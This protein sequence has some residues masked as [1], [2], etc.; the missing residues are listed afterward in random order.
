GDQVIVSATVSP[1]F[2]E[3]GKVTHYVG[4]LFDVTKAKKAEKQL[5]L[6]ATVFDSATEAV[7]VSDANNQILT[8]NR[9]FSV[10]TGY[11]YD[12][13]VGKNPKILSSGR[14]DGDYYLGMYK[15]LEEAGSWEGE[16]WNRR[17]NGS[18]YPEWLTIT[19]L[20]D[21]RGVHEGYVAI[22]SDITK[23]KEDELR[24]IHQANY[25]SLTGLA[26]RNLFS[27]RYTRAIERAERE[28]S[29]LALLFIDLDR[30]KY[31]N[32]TLGHAIG[33]MLLQEVTRRLVS[34]L[35]KTDTAARLGG[36]EFAVILPN[37]RSMVSLE[38]LVKRI[39]SKLSDP[40][41]LDGHDI[42]ISASIGIT[43]YPDDA[44]EASVLLKN[45]DSAMYMA[46]E[47]GRNDFHFYTEELSQQAEKRREIEHA[48]HHG[49]KNQEFEVHYQPI[50][51][52]KGGRVASAEALVRWHRQGHGM[53][54]PDHFIPL[55]EE[56]GLIIPIGSF[57]LRQ[58]CEDA[59]KWGEL[60]D[61]PPAVAVNLSSFQFQRQD[62]CKIV[63]EILAETGL[64]P[65][66]LILEIT[67]R[68]LIIDTDDVLG[69]LHRIRGL[70]VGLAI[71]DFGTGY[72]SLSYL[73]KFPITK[74]KIDKSFVQEL[75]NSKDDKALVS[76][77]L[78]MAES[79][80]LEVVAEGIETSAQNE[81]L[82]DNNCTFGQ[83]Y[84]YSKPLPVQG[85]E[86]FMESQIKEQGAVSEPA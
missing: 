13:V 32:D 20:F 56:I 71:D 73:K 76:A 9:A 37:I 14:Q 75:E 22:F 59:V 47:K 79:L 1:I 18:I 64:P 58:A 53:V 83:G 72:S 12:E 23:R 44:E 19:K 21:D 57:I 7:M 4:A 78:H 85:F 67:E 60:Y 17:K 46:K 35:R 81:F 61:N 27:D 74:L 48:L 5:R 50:V 45:A 39:L 43:L 33:D 34:E 55:A 42:F 63:E 11:D 66:R 51:D 30:F 68:L 82:R 6:A 8:I 41:K 65:E 84:L 49:I 36:D 31:V 52:M 28:G 16:I 24:I 10:I 15:T 80:N 3:F 77:I 25:D 38:Q 54:P 70:G 2:N 29:E 86:D 69:Q 26:N 62:M 40:Y